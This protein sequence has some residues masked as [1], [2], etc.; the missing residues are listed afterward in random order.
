MKKNRRALKYIVT[1]A[2][3]LAFAFMIMAYE[4][5]FDA[6]YTDLI[7]KFLCDGFFI[8]GILLFCVGLLV[9]AA[10]GGT[11]DMLTYGM[12]TLIYSFRRDP[13]ARGA[14]KSFY[15]YRR[16]K[17]KRNHSFGYLLVVGGAMLLISVVFLL[18]FN[19]YYMGA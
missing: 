4:G 7:M 5:I 3:G 18:L 17:Q 10:N 2:I 15:E 13:T 19:H 16:E 11:F 14:E 8:S 9:V 1:S 12:K 6:V